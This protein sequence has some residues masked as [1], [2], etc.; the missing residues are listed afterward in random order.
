MRN[1]LWSALGS[2]ARIGVAPDDRWLCCTAAAPRR[3]ALDPAPQRD[4][5]R[6]V[7]A[8]ARSIP[9]RSRALHRP[10]Q[11]VTLASLVP[12]MLARLLDAG[13]ELD[14]LRCV[15]LGGGPA[16]ASLIERALD[17]GV[18]VAPTYGLTEA[19]SQVDDAAARP[20]RDASPARP[21]PRSCP[22]RSGSRTGR[23][24][25]SGP[26]V[27]PGARARTAG[28]A[29]AT[30]AGS[31]T[32]GHLHVLGRADDVIVTGG[33]NVSPEEVEQ[34]LLRASR[35]GGRAAS[36]G[37][38]TPSGSR[39]WWRSSSCATAAPSS[40]AE[41]RDVLPR[42]AGRLQ[43]AEADR[44]RRRSCRATRRAS[45]AAQRSCATDSSQPADTL[46][47]H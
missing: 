1:H 18:P 35:R 20:G 34:A 7:V 41:L 37:R 40:E 22:P 8:R 12:T 29:P 44:V 46:A 26:N 9:T 10:E 13:A 23:I 6:A 14:R 42:A 4:L 45:C 28:C 47:A 11:P 17:A 25:V 3:R 38:R 2:A 27:A 16:P 24:L 39:R 19:A 15:L 43:G 5:R 21:A 33:E 36:P 32:D 31:T 30:S